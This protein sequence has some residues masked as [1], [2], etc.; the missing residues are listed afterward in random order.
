VFNPTV[1]SDPEQINSTLFPFNGNCLQDLK[2][3]VEH[4]WMIE[5]ALINKIT[6][7]I[8]TIIDWELVKLVVD[9]WWLF[10]VDKSAELRKSLLN[11]LA[12]NTVLLQQLKDKIELIKDVHF[13]CDKL[14]SKTWTGP[15]HCQ[16]CNAEFRRKATQTAN[17]CDYEAKEVNNFHIEEGIVLGKYLNISICP[18]CARKEEWIEVGVGG[19]ELKNWSCLRVIGRSD[20]SSTFTGVPKLWRNQIFIQ[21]QFV[22]QRMFTL[23]TKDAEKYIGNYSELFDDWVYKKQKN[24]RYIKAQKKISLSNTAKYYH[25]IFENKSEYDEKNDRFDWPTEKKSVW[26]T[27]YGE[28]RF[29]GFAG[30]DEKVL[31]QIGGAPEMLKELKKLLNTK[32][33]PKGQEPQNMEIFQKYCYSSFYKQSGK[34]VRMVGFSSGK[35]YKGRN[36]CFA[37][38]FKHGEEVQSAVLD[39]QKTNQLHHYWPKEDVQDL[40]ELRKKIKEK[41]EKIEKLKKEKEEMLKAL[42]AKTTKQQ[43]DT[44]DSDIANYIRKKSPRILEIFEDVKYLVCILQLGLAIEFPALAPAL[45][46]NLSEEV[47]DGKEYQNVDALIYYPKHSVVPHVDDAGLAKR[48]TLNTYVVLKFDETAGPSILCN[49]SETGGTGANCCWKECDRNHPDHGGHQVISEMEVYWM[50]GRGAFGGPMHA[51]HGLLRKANRLFAGFDTE[52]YSL[53]LRPV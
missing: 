26:Y 36:T 5:P 25:K 22:P 50:I 43:I 37:Q 7:S 19:E 29:T 3:R 18:K 13:G 34:D 23:K 21:G 1:I 49:C 17:R 35:T 53:V 41:E 32:I 44:K 8:E 12:K 42:E 28:M 52:Q 2:Y 10:P 46:K 20:D 48:G 33:F 45:L 39:N 16:H 9:S 6:E 40:V 31:K 51:L 4:L 38:L 24:I 27:N 11:C 30:Y 47:M 15:K 14:Y